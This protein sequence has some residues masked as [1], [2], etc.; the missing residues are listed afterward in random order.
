MG[1][2]MRKQDNCHWIVEMLIKGII[3][4]KPD[5]CIF[6]YMERH[7]IIILGCLDVSVWLAVGFWCSTMYVWSKNCCVSLCVCVCVCVCVR[8]CTCIQ[9]CPTLTD[10]MNCS[11]PG[12]YVHGISQARIFKGVANSFSRG[13]SWPR[14]QTCVSYVSCIDRRVLYP[15]SFSISLLLL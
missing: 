14:D 10:S 5:T 2:R 13:S 15:W 1:F 3:A 8:V 4:V 6:P 7:W 9:S 12:S 11:L